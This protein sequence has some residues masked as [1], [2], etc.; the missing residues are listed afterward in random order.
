MFLGHTAIFVTGSGLSKR[1]T[2]LPL[3]VIT[4]EHLQL[5]ARAC[6]SIWPPAWWREDLGSGAGPPD[7]CTAV[8][9][10]LTP[11]RTAWPSQPGPRSHLLLYPFFAPGHG[12]PTVVTGHSESWEYEERPAQAPDGGREIH[13]TY[14]AASVPAIFSTSR[15]TRLAT[16]LTPE[17]CQ[18][19]CGDFNNIRSWPFG[20]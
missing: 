3:T 20:V 12:Q 13:F 6:A 5:G 9:M 1:T 18:S 8:I 15:G 4:A 7:P 11:H 14:T 2:P 17:N 10:W 19:Q 16:S